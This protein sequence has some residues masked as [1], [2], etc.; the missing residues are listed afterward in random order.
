MTNPKK[1]FLCHKWDLDYPKDNN[2][3]AYYMNNN[4]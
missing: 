4:D 1:L 3:W 2:V